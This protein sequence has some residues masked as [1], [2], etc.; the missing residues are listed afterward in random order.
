MPVRE[1]QMTAF[2]STPAGYL[3]APTS[4]DASFGLADAVCAYPDPN[5]E[6]CGE[7]DLL[8]SAGNTNT[9]GDEMALTYQFDGTGEQV[10]LS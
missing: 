6:I 8:C 3:N 4:G 9:R 1:L 10:G 5:H 2:S 7:W